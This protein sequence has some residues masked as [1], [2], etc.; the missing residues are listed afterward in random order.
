MVSGVF[1]CLPMP[2][3]AGG[4]PSRVLKRW[5]GDGWR[6]VLG[7]CGRV[8]CLLVGFLRLVVVKPWA[9]SGLLCVGSAIGPG[10]CE[11]DVGCGGSWFGD[12][13]PAESPADS[14]RF[15]ID[16]QIHLQT[17]RKQIQLQEWT[18]ISI[19]SSGCGL[20]WARLARKLCT[21]GGTVIF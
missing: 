21:R 7:Q 18:I 8:R 6:R 11:G 13:V 1:P 12:R 2:G 17:M 9:A 20:S 3:F 19:P 5:S 16:G 4:P 14:L 15:R 10:G